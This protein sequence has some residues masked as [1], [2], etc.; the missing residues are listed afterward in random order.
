MNNDESEMER[1]GLLMILMEKMEYDVRAEEDAEWSWKMDDN[2][3]VLKCLLR[4]CR[5]F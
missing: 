5:T 1:G 2:E 3:S 4:S